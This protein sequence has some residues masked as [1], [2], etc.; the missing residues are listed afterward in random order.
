MNP[1]LN[2]ERR[3]RSWSGFLGSQPTGHE[4]PVDNCRY[5]NGDIYDKPWLF[6]KINVTLI[7]YLFI[8]LFSL[9]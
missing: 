5:I 2:Y 3:A 7:I 6:Q 1:T 4:L 8:Y 9:F